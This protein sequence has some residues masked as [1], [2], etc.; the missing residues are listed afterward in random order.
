MLI[1]AKSRNEI[2]HY[3]SE[4]WNVGERQIDKYIAQARKLIQSEIQKNI[5]YDYA[6]A[7]RRY[8][9][10]YQSA[11]DN[12]DYR[13]ASSINKEIANLQGL[14]KIQIEHSGNIEFISNIPD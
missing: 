8:E 4:N 14:Y 11:I 7:V 13:L 3:S 1:K 10:L 12:R 2:I 9:T 6:K 5:E